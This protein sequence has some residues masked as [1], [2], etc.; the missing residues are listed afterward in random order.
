MCVSTKLSFGVSQAVSGNFLKLGVRGVPDEFSNFS[1]SGDLGAFQG[2]LNS[3]RTVLENFRGF[4]EFQGCSTGVTVDFRS[5]P[6]IFNGFRGFQEYSKG[7]QRFSDG[8]KSSSRVS[9]T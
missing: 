4:Q 9:T 1:V 5:V 7:S 2:F 6:T 3:F 8:S